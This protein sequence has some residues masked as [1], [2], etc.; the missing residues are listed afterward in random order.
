MNS[1]DLDGF[2]ISLAVRLYQQPLNTNEMKTTK[3]TLD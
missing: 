1:S 3:E 2:L